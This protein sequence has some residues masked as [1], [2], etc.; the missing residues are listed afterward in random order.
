LWVEAAGSGNAPTYSA[1][2]ALDYTTEFGG[3][4]DGSRYA[5][6]TTGGG[7]TIHLGPCAGTLPADWLSRCRL[8]TLAHDRP[9][10][11]LAQFHHLTGLPFG[12]SAAAGMGAHIES[13]YNDPT[14]PRSYV[15]ATQPQ[16]TTDAIAAALRT[17]PDAPIAPVFVPLRDDDF[18]DRLGRDVR[19]DAIR[20]AMVDAYTDRLTHAGL[21]GRLRSDATDAYIAAE[22]RL[23]IASTIA[24]A[25]GATS[26]EISGG[27]T[28]ANNYTRMAVALAKQ[29]LGSTAAR[30]V[31]ILDSGA[32]YP[33]DNHYSVS[34]PGQLQTRSEQQAL[35]MTANVASIL[36]ALVTAAFDLD[37][38]LI[39]VH[40][41]FGRVW[42][43]T[44]VTN[45]WSDGY[46]ALLIG[47]HIDAGD[48]GLVGEMSYAALGPDMATTASP[49]AGWTTSAQA[50][51]P[52]DLRA[53]LLAAAGL[54]PV[55]DGLVST[56]D[57]HPDLPTSKADLRTTFFG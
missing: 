14:V 30:H 37:D 43:S 20:S 29:L 54:D 52:S 38:V 19:P 32:Q 11:P 46:A 22:S 36:D 34:G 57:L 2:D 51:S 12:R 3:L 53:G 16:T 50:L 10:H 4:L 48:N 28:F 18:L 41:E 9:V 56:A 40:S 23:G 44:Q 25:L 13:F 21:G 5:I 31:C 55:A 8:V 17:T 1:L 15:I 33:W 7:E 47:G 49:P 39:C 45:H 27:I 24:S 35:E 26:L 6:G 42:Q